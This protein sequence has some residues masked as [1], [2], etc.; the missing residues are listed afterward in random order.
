MGQ[1]KGAYLEEFPV[2]TRVRIKDVT[3]LEEFRSSW[4]LHNPLSAE[5]LQFGGAHQHRDGR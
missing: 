4:K 1:L 3:E 2:G 5:Q